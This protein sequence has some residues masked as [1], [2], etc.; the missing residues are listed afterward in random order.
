MSNLQRILE[1]SRHGNRLPPDNSCF[2]NSYGAKGP[3]QSINRTLA[4][5][6]RA[7]DR[8]GG[9]SHKP[10]I[11]NIKDRVCAASWKIKSDGKPKDPFHWTKEEVLTASGVYCGS[12]CAHIPACLRRCENAWEYYRQ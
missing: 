4:G 7:V 5:W 2:G 8:F 11:E 10:Y 3:L 9:Y 12:R 1:Y 6:A